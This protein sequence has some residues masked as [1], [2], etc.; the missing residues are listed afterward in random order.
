MDKFRA[1]VR[2]LSEEI[3]TKNGE[4]LLQSDAMRDDAKHVKERK[5]M[6]PVS[7]LLGDACKLAGFSY[8]EVLMSSELTQR[9]SLN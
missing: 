7:S 6:G 8:A 5:P 4:S 9:M 1:A 2:R 3:E